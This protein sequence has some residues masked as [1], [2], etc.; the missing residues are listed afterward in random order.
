MSLLSVRAI[1]QAN[2]TTGT[3]PVSQDFDVS[4]VSETPVIGLYELSGGIT[5]GT[6]ADGLRIGIG[7]ADSSIQRSLCGMC[8]DAQT[9]TTADAEG[10][11]DNATVFQLTNATN[12]TLNGEGSWTA[13]HAGG[14]NISWADLLGN[15][16]LCRA[17]YFFGDA[18]Q[19]SVHQLTTSAS[20]GGTA[21][22]TGRPFTVNFAIVFGG[23]AAFTADQ[24]FTHFNYGIGY[25]CRNSYD[26]SINQA[27]SY[28]YAADRNASATSCAQ[29]I[30]DTGVFK[31]CSTSGTSSVDGPRLDVTDMADGITITTRDVAAATDVIVV[32]LSI[33]KHRCWVGIPSLTTTSSGVKNITEPNFKPK[34]Y[35][36]LGTAIT[37]T[38]MVRGNA[39]ALHLSHGFANGTEEDCFSIQNEDG[40]ATSDSRCVKD[41]SILRLL[42]DAGGTSLGISHS[43][44]GAKGPDVNVTTVSG[45]NQMCVFAAISADPVIIPQLHHPPSRVHRL[46]RM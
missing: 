32:L 39:E 38:N 24:T 43:A 20:I 26:R 10:R 30:F 36:T 4:G 18:V 29:S 37:Q 41:N 1:T 23:N 14:S 27:G 12:N 21:S 13:F 16:F 40:V 15:L 42:D 44:M 45:S 3:P 8:E 11:A 46:M 25:A 19:G 28:T 31:L 34:C 2:T 17:T 7:A 6:I 22:I 9:T 33:P 5:A 35:W